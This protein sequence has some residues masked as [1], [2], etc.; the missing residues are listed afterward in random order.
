VSEYTNFDNQIC[1]NRKTPFRNAKLKT[2]ISD[3]GGSV[4]VFI[5]SG[6]T[7]NLAAG[8]RQSFGGVIGRRGNKNSSWAES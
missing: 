4:H 6:R 3:K 1:G 2:K 5:P 8:K 7:K